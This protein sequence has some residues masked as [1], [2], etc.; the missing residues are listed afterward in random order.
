MTHPHLPSSKIGK[1][2]KCQSLPILFTCRPFYPARP[3]LFTICQLLPSAA[4]HMRCAG[5]SATATATAVLASDNQISSD[6]HREA[7]QGHHTETALSSA[8]CCCRCARCLQHFCAL[9]RQRLSPRR[10]W[11]PASVSNCCGRPQMRTAD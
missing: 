5:R 2:I 1:L 7:A 8:R 9:P 6:L 3:Q 10:R 4:H 11:L